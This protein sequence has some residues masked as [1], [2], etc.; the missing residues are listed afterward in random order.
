MSA[1]VS[2]PPEQP[3][4]DAGAPR[5]QIALKDLRH[6]H[7]E[8]DDKLFTKIEDLYEAGWKLLAKA[9]DYIPASNFEATKSYDHRLKLATCLPY[10]GQIV[11]QFASDLFS[12]PVNVI[13]AGD[14]KNP[15]TPGEYPDCDYYTAFAKDA[16]G[17][18]QS[19]SEILS[20][21]VKTALK[22]RRAYLFVDAP[23]LPRDAPAPV[24]RAEEDASDLRR[25]YVYELPP[26]ELIDW[27]CDRKGEY[28]WL[29][30]HSMDEEQSSPA[31]LRTT[32]REIFTIWTRGKS[33]D[34]GA[35]WARYVAEYDPNQ[36]PDDTLLVGL[37]DNDTT[38]F[39]R[40]PILKL[41]LSKGLWVGN[42]VGTQQLEHWR[43]RSELIGSESR[44][45][46]AIPTTF[47]GPEMSATGFNLPGEK[48]QDPNRGA[49]PVAE[50]KSRGTV[51]LGSDDRFEFVEPA[52]KSYALID[53]ELD[54]LKD[55]MFRVVHMMAASVKNTPG[56]LGRSGLS[57]QKDGEAT[58]KVLSALGEKVRG[59]CLRTY[60]TISKARSEDVVWVAHGLDSYEV[61]D[62]EQVIEESLALQ[63][64]AIPSPTFKKEHA[65]R[66]VG[67][68][69]PNL[70]PATVA[71]IAEE[72]DEG[73]DALKDE[74]DAEVEA[75]G[76]ERDARVKEAK[77][78]TP[79]VIN[80]PGA[81]GPPKPGGPPAA[82]KPPPPKS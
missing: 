62:R 64:V 77:N 71:Q 36:P 37:D 13:P 79:P 60:D 9:R 14:A 10:F 63:E 35:S 59:L 30:T 82:K 11:D 6:C 58:A 21:V 54:G 18:G 34:D 41:E 61:D 1:A 72:I 55:E 69:V 3:A 73:V 25:C 4:N 29:V 5:A 16:D 56:S 67:K 49:N 75:T 17:G 26:L 42:K 39:R 38:S 7:K 78:P 44:S 19:L 28:E 66:I 45:C 68:L 32:V 27:K 43:R 40:I 53:K 52:G 51:R 70:P 46:H 81:G 47:L 65:K 22:L 57:K 74:A 80:V 50:F 48:Q 33:K 76:A 20:G 2:L 24:N 12:Q 8:Y 31:S 23:E 15:Q